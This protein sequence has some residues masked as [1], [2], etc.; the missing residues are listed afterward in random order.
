[1]S[2]RETRKRFAAQLDDDIAADELAIEN[3]TRSLEAK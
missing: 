2:E 3:A 1:M